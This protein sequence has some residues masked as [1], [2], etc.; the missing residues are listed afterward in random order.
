MNLNFEAKPHIKLLQ[1]S[2]RKMEK[3]NETSSRSI[4]SASILKLSN[5]T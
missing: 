1:Q 3:E 2:T 5:K 4:Q